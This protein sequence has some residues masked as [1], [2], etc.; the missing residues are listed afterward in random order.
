VTLP[1]GSTAPRI[2]GFRLWIW[3]G[4]LCGVIGLRW[5]PG[6]SELPPYVL[7]HIGYVV[8]PWKRRRG[9]ARAALGM[10]L[11]RARAEELDSVEI[12][13]DP[14]NLA[15]RRVIEANGGVL[16]AT[17]TKPAQYGS[18]PGLR[19]RIDLRAPR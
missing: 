19:Y 13:T 17:F 18:V 12:T 14:D 16:V 7:G 4:E 9:Y 3:D 8:V 11:V 2:P 6:T 5:L 10:M 1:D 15:S